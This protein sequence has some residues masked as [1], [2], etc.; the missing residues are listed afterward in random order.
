MGIGEERAPRFRPLP[1]VL[2]M[3]GVS[4]GENLLHGAL[5]L[6]MCPEAITRYQQREKRHV[7]EPGGKEEDS[8]FDPLSIFHT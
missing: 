4:L 7:L 2:Q 8:I 3:L 5:F 1:L 6:Y